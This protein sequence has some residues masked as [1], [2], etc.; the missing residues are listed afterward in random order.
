MHDNDVSNNNTAVKIK[1]ATFGQQIII[2]NDTYG[3]SKGSFGHRFPGLLK[4]LV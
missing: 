2:P 4:R 1:N 3:T